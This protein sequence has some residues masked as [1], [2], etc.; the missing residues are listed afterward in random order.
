MTL[1]LLQYNK[2]INKEKKINSRINT[3]PVVI[4]I[5]AINYNNKYV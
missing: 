2:K 5:Q 3:D 4:T 1:L